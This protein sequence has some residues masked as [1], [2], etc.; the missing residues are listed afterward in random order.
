M[1][2]EIRDELM[3]VGGEKAKEMWGGGDVPTPEEFGRFLSFIT[4]EYYE[5][6][7]A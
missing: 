7:E 2:H 4:T 6:K 3:D 1:V 5:R